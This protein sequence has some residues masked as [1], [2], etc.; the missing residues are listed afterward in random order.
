MPARTAAALLAATLTIASLVFGISPRPWAGA[1]VSTRPRVSFVAAPAS[2]IL[3]HGSYPTYSSPCVSSVQPIMHARFEGT[4][5]VG[6]DTD[7]SLFVIGVLPFE[8]YLKGIAEVPRSWPAEALKA[9]VVA[10]RSY[11]LARMSYPDPT[12]DALGYDLCATT[13]CQVYTGL[14]ISDG[15]YGDRWVSAV[16]QTEG[17]ALLYN[18]RPADTLYF[19]TSNGRTL[20]NQEVFGTTQLPYLKSVKE[21]DDGESSVSHWHVEIPLDDLARFLSK[22]SDWGNEPISS[23]SRA[24]STITLEG[25]GATE[26]L[27]VTDFRIDLNYW[28]HCLDPD[29]YPSID[30][31]GSELPQTVPSKWFDLSIGGS[32]VVLDGRG[33]G[34]GVGMVQWG[35]YGKATRGLSYDDILAYYYGGLRP[36]LYPAEP[37]VIRIGIATGLNAVRIEGTGTVSIQ[38]SNIEEEPWLVKG[39]KRLRVSHSHPPPAYFAAGA[40]VHAPK[41]A[42]SGAKLAATVSVERLSVVSLL[43]RSAEG[44]DY[45]VTQGVTTAEGEIELSGTVPPMPTGTYSLIAVTTDGVD[46]ADS[47]PTTV[48]VAGLAVTPTSTTSPSPAGSPQAETSGTDWGLYVGSGIAVLALATLAFV[49]ARKRRRPR[50]S[51]WQETRPPPP[52]GR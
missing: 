23:V 33:W 5:E 41:K 7:G 14:A 31:D 45:P 42:R 46:I 19:S 36:T 38:G 10:A 24:G 18:G 27:S 48:H 39:G 47:D 52:A 30:T 22:A 34:H 32:S 12:G 28:A 40:I 20:S 3:V 50:K 17:Q 25:G 11:A 1:A 6:L 9:Q 44:V 29:H 15:P 8:D 35:A 16:E 43:L 21:K 51:A 13:A 37:A 4:I 2:T 49:L 26:T